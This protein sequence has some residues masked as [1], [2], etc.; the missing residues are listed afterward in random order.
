MSTDTLTALREARRELERIERLHFRYGLV[1]RDQVE[2]VRGLYLKARD[3][4]TAAST[5]GGVS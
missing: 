3:A 4:H 1:T 5:R 2:L